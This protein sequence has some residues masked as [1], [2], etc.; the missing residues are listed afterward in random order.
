MIEH[1]FP[2]SPP[3]PEDRCVYC[4]SWF[5]DGTEQTCVPRPASIAPEPRRRVSAMD[6]ID[7][8]AARIAELRAE[9]DAAMAGEV[10]GE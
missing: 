4:G 3:R 9:R 8:I 10:A 1:V 6:D 5:R 2:S 7:V